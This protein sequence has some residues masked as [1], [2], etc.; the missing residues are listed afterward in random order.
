MR[1]S[2]I[3]VS[4]VNLILF[5]GR[6]WRPCT[7]RAS[8]KVLPGVQ[9]AAD[10]FCCAPGFSKISP[11]FGL[12]QKMLH[13]HNHVISIFIQF[14]KVTSWNEAKIEG[15]QFSKVAFEGLFL[16]DIKKKKTFLWPTQCCWKCHRSAAEYKQKTNEDLKCLISYL[17][18]LFVHN[19][20]TI[21]NIESST[22]GSVPKNVPWDLLGRCPLPSCRPGNRNRRKD[23]DGSWRKG[24]GNAR[25]TR[26]TCEHLIE[27]DHE[28]QPVASGEIVPLHTIFLAAKSVSEEVQ[29]MRKPIPNESF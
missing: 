4:Q 15:P 20:V 10:F 11:C 2:H 25:I 9:I 22:P 5:F 13:K 18:C 14:T 21:H 17:F 26:N 24:W 12:A 6:P 16:P 27:E 28:R 19:L 1:S 7:W 29:R 3:W 23:G 8:P